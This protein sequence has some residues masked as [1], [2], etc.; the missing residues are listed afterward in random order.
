MASMLGET[1]LLDGSIASADHNLRIA[2]ASQDAFIF[3]GTLR[4]NV[5]LG[6]AFD[7]ARYNAV[8]NACGLAPDITRLTKGDA[9]VLGDKGIV[10]SGGQRQRVASVSVFNGSHHPPLMPIVLAAFVVGRPWLALCTQ[11]HPSY[12]WMIRSGTSVDNSKF[13]GRI[14]RWPFP[15]LWMLRR[16]YKVGA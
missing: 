10:L 6:A 2:Y 14:E 15:A 16:K 3:P 9:T 13:K 1:T 4:D 8:I 7:A 11:M 5:L 12:S